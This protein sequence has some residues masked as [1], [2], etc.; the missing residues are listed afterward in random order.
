MNPVLERYTRIKP[1]AGTQLNRSHPLVRNLTACWIWSTSANRSYDS[2]SGRLATLTTGYNIEPGPV[3]PVRGLALECAASGTARVTFPSI[4]STT[5]FTIE[6]WWYFRTLTGYAQLCGQPSNLGLQHLDDDIDWFNGSDNLGTIALTAN[7][8]EHVVFSVA[9]NT[10]TFYINGASAGTVASVGSLGLQEMGNDDA[11]E[12][13]DGYNGLTRIWTGR[14]LNQREIR[15]LY[16]NPYAMFVPVVP[17]ILGKAAGAGAQTISPTGRASTVAF[18]T[19]KLNPIIFPGAKASGLV[20]G[21]L[22]ANPIIRPAA[23]A[24]T[25]ALG[26]PTLVPGAVTISPASRASSLAIGAPQLK[27]IIL[28]ASRASSLGV[29]TPVVT[30]ITLVSPTGIASTLALGSPSLALQISP[31]GLASSLAFGTVKLNPVIIMAGRASSLVIGT[32]AM[33]TGNIVVPDGR[34]STLAFGTPKLNPTILLT[35]RTSTLGVGSPTVKGLWTIAP[36]GRASTL[37]LGQPNLVS[38]LIMAGRGST[39]AYGVLKLNPTIRM[40]GKASGL[41][42]GQLTIF[43]GVLGAPELEPPFTVVT[44]VMVRLVV[45]PQLERSVL[46]PELDRTVE[47]G[48]G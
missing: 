34:G 36:T 11:G 44:P 15:E 31:T 17:R 2:I 13:V 12:V 41:A 18:G 22:K 43:S 48:D 47:M 5:T 21:T 29:G 14:A 32:P 39:L 37:A 19:S 25:L 23:R 27:L 10:G 28:P 8:W 26:S 1:V 45:T 3:G 7:R 38:I 46:T 42:F 40:T 9:A 16:N 20:F 4:T 30:P 33:L 24:S 35:S 6:Q